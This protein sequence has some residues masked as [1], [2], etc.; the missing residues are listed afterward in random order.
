MHH[1]SQGF[2][3]AGG[4]PR[5]AAQALRI[6]QQPS[7]GV[8]SGQL[9]GGQDAAK[10]ADGGSPV[11]A[12]RAAAGAAGV[13]RAAQGACG[14]VVVERYGWMSE[15]HAAAGA[16]VEQR[17]QRLALSL[18]LPALLAERRCRECAIEYSQGLCGVLEQ[19]GQGAVQGLVVGRELRRLR[20]QG[21]VWLHR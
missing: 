4:W 6:V 7:I 21:L 19:R 2:N 3:C 15:E 1:G 5:L 12:A 17:G 18:P 13:E 10:Q 14:K 9:D 8:E 20:L 11:R 16:V